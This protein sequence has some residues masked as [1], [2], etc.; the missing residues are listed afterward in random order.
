MADCSLR[1]FI[2]YLF[3]LVPC[4]NW[5]IIKFIYTQISKPCQ[6]YCW[7]HIWSTKYINMR[8][9]FGLIIILITCILIICA[10]AIWKGLDSFVFAW[11]LNFMLMMSLLSLTQTLK[12]KFTSKYY[13]IK[14][15][16][17]DG[18]LYHFLGINIF[19]KILV[20]IGWE[21]INKKANPVTKSL[22]SL[23]L[24]E[25]GTKQ[26]EFGHLVIFFIVM[27]INIFVAIKFG[28]FQ[29]I[30]LLILNVLLNFYPIIL[31]RFNRPRFKKTID[32]I[33]RQL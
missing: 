31:Q 8:K 4:D 28:F 5:T 23:L 6:T 15:W 7:K 19:R 22:N 17:K 27:G 32:S 14:E 9:Y 11:I 25:Y 2:S 10:V 12:F 21:K 30:W 3:N 13:K 1:H 24:L 33:K 26:S 18:E 29:S 20:F 16:E